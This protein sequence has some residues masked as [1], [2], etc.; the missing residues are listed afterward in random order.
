MVMITADMHEQTSRVPEMLRGLGAQVEIRS[1]SRGDYIVGPQSLVER[2]TVADLHGSIASG[3]FWQQIGKI[4]TVRWPYLLIEGR[5][6]FTGPVAANAIRG[7]CLAV[8]D[9]GVTIIRTEDTPDTAAWL[10]RVA[11]R[12]R[13]AAIRNRPVYAQRPKSGAAPVA[14]A[15][16]ACARGVSVETAR[17][18]LN[19]FGSLRAVGDASLDD[20]LALPGVGVQRAS[21]IT[22]LM[23]GS[24]HSVEPNGV[25]RAT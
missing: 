5:S 12:R 24:S 8:T 1:L 3:R 16:L 14:E 13:G 15:A 22:A 18:V 20:L 6:I 25:H 10:C 21:A 7:L 23:R 11:L 2:K 4:R 9:L 19:H 17:T